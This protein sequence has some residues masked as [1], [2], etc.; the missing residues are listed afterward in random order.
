MATAQHLR[1]AV[2][3]TTGLKIFQRS[4]CNAHASAAPSPKTPEG[5]Y[6]CTPPALQVDTSL[7]YNLPWFRF[8][9]TI[10]SKSPYKRTLYSF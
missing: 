10:E 3:V 4:I 6:I 8:L 7:L 5:L 2:K 9:D 1:M